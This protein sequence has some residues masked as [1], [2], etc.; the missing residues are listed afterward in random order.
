MP[1]GCRAYISV[2][3]I[4]VRVLLEELVDKRRA[5][6]FGREMKRRLARLRSRERRDRI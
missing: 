2:L 3:G 1:Q 4:Y 5:V 6:V